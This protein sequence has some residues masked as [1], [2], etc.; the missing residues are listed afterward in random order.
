MASLSFIWFPSREY[1]IFKNGGNVVGGGIIAMA[2]TRDGEKKSTP[3]TI[4]L[5]FMPSE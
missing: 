3:K 4:V 1:E 5:I 2:K